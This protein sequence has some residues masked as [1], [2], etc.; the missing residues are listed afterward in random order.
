MTAKNVKC[1]T[2]IKNS[3]LHKVEIRPR[4]S[5]TATIE[6]STMVASS[7]KQKQ[8]QNAGVEFFSWLHSNEL[9]V[10]SSLQTLAAAAETPLAVIP[11]R[12]SS[13]R[14]QTSA[15]INTGVRDEDS[16]G[17]KKKKNTF[18][19]A[20]ATTSRQVTGD[21]RQI[22]ASSSTEVLTE[23]VADDLDVVVGGCEGRTVALILRATV[24]P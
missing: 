19:P 5:G 3:R 13:P 1:G 21:S 16:D 18:D 11:E 24:R 8:R 9:S 2:V 12:D 20:T 15:N 17:K 14:L 22:S 23:P 6:S 4:G 10:A 7:R